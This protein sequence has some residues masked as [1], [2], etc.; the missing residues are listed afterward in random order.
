MNRTATGDPTWVVD[1]GVDDRRA[2][3]T[4]AAAFHKVGPLIGA[5]GAQVR[6]MSWLLVGVGVGLI[7]ANEGRGRGGCGLGGVGDA[8]RT[9][10]ELCE[11][12][13]QPDSGANAGAAVGAF[14]HGR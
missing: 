2:A 5:V 10:K 11:F 13:L 8:R 9:H 14:V 6:G 4:V 7:E 1:G 12:L 3:M